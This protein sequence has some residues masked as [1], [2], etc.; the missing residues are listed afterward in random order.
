[1]S[2][3][4]DP[5]VWVDKLP[6]KEFEAG[7]GSHTPMLSGPT[8]VSGDEILAPAGDQG[9]SRVMG[10][11]GLQVHCTN[12]PCHPP[13]VKGLGRFHFQSELELRQPLAHQGG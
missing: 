5:V 3:P 11:V 8:K 12:E 13:P 10:A 7:F 9:Y 1:V 2:E 6:R 4:N